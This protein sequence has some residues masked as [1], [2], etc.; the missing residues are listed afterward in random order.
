ML[1]RFGGDTAISIYAY[2]SSID[3]NMVIVIPAKAATADRGAIGDVGS[4]ELIDEC[5]EN[6][7]TIDPQVQV[8][9]LNYCFMQS[10]SDSSKIINP[11]RAHGGIQI[12]SGCERVKVSHNFIR[13]G[14]GNGITLGSYLE[15]DSI[16]DGSSAGGKIKVEKIQTTYG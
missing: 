6:A 8:A 7:E 2:D 16:S 9:Y 10:S 15:T 11:F 3:G 12:A 4:E 5:I 14:W 1:D 13:G